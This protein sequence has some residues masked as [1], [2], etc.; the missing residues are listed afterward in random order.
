MASESKTDSIADGSQPF[1]GWASNVND[2]AI[3]HKKKRK[4]RRAEA[5]SAP[6]TL[7]SLM[8][9][10]TILLV[11]LLKSYATSPIEV[12]DPA[13][14]VPTST[15]KETVEEATVV[16]ITGPQKQVPNPND[17]KS[18]VVV[19]NTPAIVVDGAAVLQLDAATYRVKAED[20]DAASGGYVIKPL[21]AKLK[22]AKQ[23][24][25]AT[26]A[27]SDSVGHSG[28]VVIIAD[29]RTPYRVLTDVLVTCGEA[30]FGEFK[31]AIVKE[32]G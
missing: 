3:R 25:E 29:K 11:Y 15:S 28:K 14:Q 17:P 10:V 5:Q 1:K 24:L 7:N 4:K 16:M 32:S 23:M 9:I 18:S 2:G 19:Q 22:E 13:V 8:D 30:G 26:A 31:F 27:V 21:S 20:K 6:L 12:K